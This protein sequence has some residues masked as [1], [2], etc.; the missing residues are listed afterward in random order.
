[1]RMRKFAL[2]LMAV[3]AAFSAFAQAEPDPAD[4]ERV[5]VP[6][7]TQ[8]SHGQQGSLWTTTLRIFNGDDQPVELIGPTSE[9]SLV[10][11]P[12]QTETESIAPLMRGHEG[13]FLYV[14]KAQ[15]ATT[16]F[17]LRVANNAKG[18][19]VGNEIPV[20]RESEAKGD[21]A[22]IEIPD[23]SRY[24]VALRIYGFTEAPMQVGVKILRE[25]GPTVIRQS[26]V[27][28]QGIVHVNPEPFPLH[29]AYG[30]INPFPRPLPFQPG[31]APMMRIEITNFHTIVSP[32]PP[33]IWAFISITDNQTGEV[34]IVE[35][36]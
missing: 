29:P 15:L 12:E 23:N 33:P 8:T 17:S 25:D 32:P 18:N 30:V 22:F 19:L 5:L 34:T 4:Y 9:I 13:A 16:M 20:V 28:L 2:G 10:V 3:F 11:D 21:L 1:M 14:P 36:E 6:L 35:P 26:T 31:N 27:D 24:R 7:T